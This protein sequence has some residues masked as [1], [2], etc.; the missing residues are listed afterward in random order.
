MNENVQENGAEFLGIVDDGLSCAGHIAAEKPLKTENRDNCITYTQKVFLHADSKE[1]PW[2]H[3]LH[4]YNTRHRSQYTLPAHHLSLYKKKPS[5]ISPKLLNHLPAEIRNLT[6]NM[7]KRKLEDSLSQ[8]PV[9]SLLE[10]L[11]HEDN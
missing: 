7:L 9:Y 5:Y 6:E 11:H 10:Y 1:L 2:H 3:D 8:R 4:G